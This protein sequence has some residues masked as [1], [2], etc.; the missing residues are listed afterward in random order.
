MPEIS[1][2]FWIRPG[3]LP[4]AA[5]VT[6][7]L[8]SVWGPKRCKT[9][10][11]EREPGF[12]KKIQRDYFPF[13]FFFLGFFFSFFCGTLLGIEHYLLILQYTKMLQKK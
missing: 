4:V 5:Q 12:A 3:L 10:P 11:K 6:G 13:F 9:A 7:T 1:I 8:N 2:G